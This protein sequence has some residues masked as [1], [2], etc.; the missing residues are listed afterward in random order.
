MLEIVGQILRSYHKEHGIDVS[1]GND[2]GMPPIRTSLLC[3]YIEERG[4]VDKIALFKV[5]IESK[6][7]VAQVQKFQGQT[8]PYSGT[9]KLAKIFFAKNHN[10]CW[11]RFAVCK[12][13]YHCMIDRKPED[14]VSKT[15]NLT[16]LLE[17]LAEDTTALTGKFAPLDSEQKAELFALET[18][19]PMEFRL[20]YLESSADEKTVQEMAESFKIPAVYARIACRSTYNQMTLQLRGRLEDIK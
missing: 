1:R 9:Q 14:R 20:D 19:F 18:L 5:E 8:S 17:L 16:K 3:P 15:T 10:Y 4:V 2:T 13:M 6:H 11:R 7:I 12:E